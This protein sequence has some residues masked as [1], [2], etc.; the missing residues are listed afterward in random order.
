[1]NQND[2]TVQTLG[3]NG[4]LCGI[5]GGLKSSRLVSTGSNEAKYRGVAGDCVEVMVGKDGRRSVQLSV[6]VA[7]YMGICTRDKGT[8]KKEMADT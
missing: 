1:M 2:D 6:Q 7:R 5:K 3:P 8:S 4:Y